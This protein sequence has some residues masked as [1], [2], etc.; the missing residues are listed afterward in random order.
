M[1]NINKQK[2]SRYP[3]RIF[4]DKDIKNNFKNHQL[5]GSITVSL[6]INFLYFKYY[7]FSSTSFNISKDSFITIST[8][9]LIIFLIMIAWFPKLIMYTGVYSLITF[10]TNFMVSIFYLIF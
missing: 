9:L 1:N 8:I 3:K 7:I 4:K 6:V 2:K 5:W 10:A